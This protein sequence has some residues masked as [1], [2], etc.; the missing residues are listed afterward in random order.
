MSLH[1]LFVKILEVHMT[2]L[3]YQIN[4]E[5]KPA[6][7]IRTKDRTVI[8][9][10]HLTREQVNVANEDLEREGIKTRKWIIKDE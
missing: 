6:I 3:K 1:T 7:F 10:H 2:K 9:I 5:S 4:E 8:G